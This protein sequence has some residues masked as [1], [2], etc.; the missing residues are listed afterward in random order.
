MTGPKTHPDELIKAL[1]TIAKSHGYSLTKVE[2]TPTTRASCD[3]VEYSYFTEYA[4]VTDMKTG[5]ETLHM[6]DG[7]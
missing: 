4:G 1:R 2:F 3:T 5:V 6:A 7:H